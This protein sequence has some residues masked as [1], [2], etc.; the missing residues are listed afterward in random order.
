MWT[1]SDVT[2]VSWGTQLH[3][4][5]EAA[6]MAQEKLGISTEVIDIRTIVPWDQDTV[7]NVSTLGARYCD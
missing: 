1:G 4:A 3:V 2:L 6:E 5:R 7:I